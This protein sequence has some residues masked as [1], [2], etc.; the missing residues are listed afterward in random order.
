MKSL[1]S[2][3]LSCLAQHCITKAHRMIEIVQ[4][5]CHFAI[6]VH[7]RL[8]SFKHERDNVYVNESMMMMMMMMG[9]LYF[10]FVILCATKKRRVIS[11]CRHNVRARY[12]QFMNLCSQHK[13]ELVCLIFTFPLL[14]KKKCDLIH[15]LC[16]ST[17]EFLGFWM[18]VAFHYYF[19]LSLSLKFYSFSLLLR[20]FLM[21]SYRFYF[22][23]CT[24]I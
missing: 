3:L 16:K 11:F 19:L 8:Y 20:G 10:F 5:Y 21:K 9:N 4:I 17:N 6:Y 18:G 2:S 13:E 24:D 23:F 1:L 12:E 14:S 7:V 22:I 15:N